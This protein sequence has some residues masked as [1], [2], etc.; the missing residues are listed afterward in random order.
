MTVGIC[1][2]QVQ[3]F[4]NTLNNFALLTFFSAFP[5]AKKSKEKKKFPL[6]Y[7]D[8]Q[9]QSFKFQSCHATTLF[10][11]PSTLRPSFYDRRCRQDSVELL[12]LLIDW[13]LKQSSGKYYSPHYPTSRT[14]T[15]T[16]NR[17]CNKQSLAL[18]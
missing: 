17:S 7:Y 6:F 14:M 9:P 15:C 3:T 10:P 13:T 18:H 4:G 8:F 12:A 5:L 11:P 2:S 1:K 16:L